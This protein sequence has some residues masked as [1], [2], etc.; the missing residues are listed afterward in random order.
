MNSSKNKAIIQAL[1]DTVFNQRQFSKLAEMIA[2]DYTNTFGDKGIAAF[3][4]TITGL[5][6]AFPDGHWQLEEVIADENKVMVKQKFTGTH[7]GP[8]QDIPPTHKTVAVTGMVVYE[9]ANGKVVRTETLT[10]RISFLQQLGVLPKDLKQVA[11]SSPQTDAVYFVDKF[12][13]PKP[14]LDLFLSQTNDNRKFIRNLPGF[15]KDQV[16]ITPVSEDDTVSVMTI[17]AWENQ[18]MLDAAK[19]AVRQ[20]YQRTGF[21]PAAF[22][23]Q[24]GISMERAQYK[25][26]PG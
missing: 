16:F 10:D 12:R 14:A 23:K 9:M 1:Y 11:A 4:K 2:P 20:E 26:M 7:T 18:A 6:A 21:D 13:V 25:H 15:I 8:F 22:C 24:W 5:S 19:A 3:Q 17:A